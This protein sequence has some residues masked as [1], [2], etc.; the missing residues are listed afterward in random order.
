L[1][2]IAEDSES[3]PH[4]YLRKKIRS[5]ENIKET[6]NES[7]IE[8]QVSEDTND[9]DLE[10]TNDIDPEDLQGVSLDDALDT[11]EGKNVPKRIAE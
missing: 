1:V 4:Y 2:H 5:L 11:I 9:I 3:E 8:M 6:F 10:N 7:E